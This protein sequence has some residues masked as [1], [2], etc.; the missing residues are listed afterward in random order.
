MRGEALGTVLRRLV[1][2]VVLLVVVLLV[3]VPLRAA[4]ARVVVVLV[5]GR[6]RRLVPVATARLAGVKNVE[7][8]CR[9]FLCGDASPERR[10]LGYRPPRPIRFADETL[11]PR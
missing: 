2:V 7:G 3:V 4:L 10:T 8:H 1:A 6:G 11:S 5:V 9:S